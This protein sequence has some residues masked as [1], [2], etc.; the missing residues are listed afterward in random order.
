LAAAL[1]DGLEGQVSPA[2]ATCAR[3]MASPVEAA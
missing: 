3:E 1:E 2:P